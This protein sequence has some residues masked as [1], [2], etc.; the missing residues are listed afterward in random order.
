[1][2]KMKQIEIGGKKYTFEL[3]RDRIIKAEEVYGVSITKVEERI[4]SQSYKT[5]VAG[6]DKHHGKL[7]VGE[8]MDLYD[9]Y[10][11]ET[12]KSME[13]VSYLMETIGN[14]INPTQ[15]KKEKK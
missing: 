15:A 5:W 8:R 1:M 10:N 3:D 2:A 4:V 9:E 11:Q 7:S 6:L 14:F 13:V 12:G